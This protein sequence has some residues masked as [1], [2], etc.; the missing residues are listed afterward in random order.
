[1]GQGKQA[2]VLTDGQVRA[3]LAAVESRRCPLRDRVMVLLSIRT[4]LR[5]KEIAKKTGATCGKTK[6]LEEGCHMYPRPPINLNIVKRGRGIKI[7]VGKREYEG[8]ATADTTVTVI[9]VGDFYGDYLETIQSSLEENSKKD[10]ILVFPV[11]ASRPPTSMYGVAHKAQH[12]GSIA[13]FA[14]VVEGKPPKFLKDFETMFPKYKGCFENIESAMLALR[15]NQQNVRVET[16]KRR[17]AANTS[18]RLPP[19]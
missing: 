19:V 18:K 10:A 4:G 1:M 17:R 5:A 11:R 7:V 2:K 15:P 16:K 6:F 12:Y 13:N 14:L 8:E 9:T 3:V